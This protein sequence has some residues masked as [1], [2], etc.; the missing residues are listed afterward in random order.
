MAYC[1]TVKEALNE[2]E[3]VLLLTHWP[4]F[5]SLSDDIKSLGINPLVIDG[6]RMLSKNNIEK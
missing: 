2:A 4:Q 6:R 5:S 1:D 3:L